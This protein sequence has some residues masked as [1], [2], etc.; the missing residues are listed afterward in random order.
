VAWGVVALIL[1]F[2]SSVVTAQDSDEEP[3]LEELREQREVAAQQLA[4]AAASIDADTATVDE[5]ATAL[6]EIAALASLQQLRLDEAVDRYDSALIQ[7]SQAEETRAE[8]LAEIVVVR[9]RV[10][11]LALAQFTGESGKQPFEIALSTDPGESARLSHLLKLQTGS[12]EDAVDQLRALEFQAEQLISQ[13]NEASS[14]AAENLAEIEHRSGELDAAISQQEALLESAEFR[15]AARETE[16]E[17]AAALVEETEATITETEE[18]L[19]DLI[20]SI[21][22]PAQVDRAD[23]VTISFHEG[24]ETRPFFQ[25]Q[26]HKDIEE[27]TRSLYELAFSQDINL[28]GWGFRTTDRQIE[29]REAHCGDSTY[30]IWLKP[31][32]ECSPPTARP[33]FSK[34]EQGRAID[35]QWNGG[36]IGPRSGTPFRW[37]AANAPQFGFVNLPSEPWHWSDGTA[38]TFDPTIALPEFLEDPT[39]EAEPDSGT[40]ELLNEALEE[41]LDGDGAPVENVPESAESGAEPDGIAPGTPESEE[42]LQSGILAFVDDE[43]GV[44]GEAIDE[45]GASADDVAEPT[46]VPDGSLDG[47]GE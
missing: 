28:G 12:A 6:D 44:A 30:D 37:L 36:S 40:A 29:L 47:E 33:G 42:S 13:R 9:E 41:E 19:A 20:R 45:E 5:L 34:H 15:L 24:L 14:L 38:N 4:D 31:A 22:A 2:S 27:Q 3:T 25:I 32:S 26:V 46:V 21:G 1:A 43:E 35:F 23:I 39:P 18:R 7:L 10:R 11:D 16:A 8:V 17:V